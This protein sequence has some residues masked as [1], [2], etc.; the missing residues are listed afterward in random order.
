MSPVISMC[1]G[2]MNEGM[3]MRSRALTCINR[4]YSDKYITQK[5]NSL[6]KPP[7]PLS[8]STSWAALYTGR[9]SQE[10]QT[11]LKGSNDA[12]FIT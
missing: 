12:K 2:G 10:N 5:K 8:I 11:T 3:D 4:I 1:G 7:Y 6:T 9:L